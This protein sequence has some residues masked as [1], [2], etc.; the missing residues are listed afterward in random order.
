MARTVKTVVAP[1]ERRFDGDREP[2]PGR[3]IHVATGVSVIDVA[4]IR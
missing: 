3:P 1:R 2:F 4:A